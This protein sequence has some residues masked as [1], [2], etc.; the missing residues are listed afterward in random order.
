[1]KLL[2]IVA[3]TREGSVNRALFDLV[4]QDLS[5]AGHAVDE[6]DYAEVENLSPY[7]HARE[8]AGLPEAVVDI[9]AR[10]K[11]ADGLVIATPEYNFSL[12]GTLKNALDWISRI[13]PYVTIDKPVLLMSASGSPVGGWRGLAALRVPLACLGAHV[14]PWEIVAGGAR[15]QDDIATLAGDPAFQDRVR[16]AVSQLSSRHGS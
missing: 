13:K 11:A 3:S 1:M 10:I 7:T 6:I 12:P 16:A 4:A 2:G 5:G 9:A 14:A 15:T 8:M